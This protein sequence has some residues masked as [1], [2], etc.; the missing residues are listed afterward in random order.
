RPL[1]PA[2]QGR[3]NRPHRHPAATREGTNGKGRPA[4]GGNASQPHHSSLRARPGGRDDTRASREC[5]RGAG[6]DGF[7][8]GA[9]ASVGKERGYWP[10]AAVEEGAG[11]GDEAGGAGTE[12]GVSARAGVRRMR[13]AS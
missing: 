8:G 1:G 13:H 10:E 11:G 9:I 12:G 5:V 6:G 2:R 7:A 3:R 4:S